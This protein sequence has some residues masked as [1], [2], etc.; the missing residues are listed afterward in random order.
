MRLFKKILWG[1]FFLASA[2][3]LLADGMGCFPEGLNAVKLILVTFF[4]IVFI[5]S[6]LKLH[7]FGIFMPLALTGV[8]LDTELGLEAISPWPLIVAGILLTIGCYI[9]FGKFANFEHKEERKFE[10]ETIEGEE[11]VVNINASFGAVTKYVNTKKLK[12]INVNLKFGAAKLYLDKA[13]IDGDNATLDINTSFSGVDV[14]IPRTWKVVNKTYA[15][16]GA[17][18]ENRNTNDEINKTLTI[19]GDVHFSGIKIIYL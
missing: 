18:E 17:V 15:K 3:I 6:V 8:V 14:Y 12:K 11:S 9:L 10:E 13:E 4:G 1:L 2:G 5:E 7:Y 16:L 19:T